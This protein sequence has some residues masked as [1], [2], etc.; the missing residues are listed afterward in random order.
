[1][2]LSLYKYFSST[3]E[4]K[5]RNGER[6]TTAPA[7][8][9]INNELFPHKWKSRH[10]QVSTMSKYKLNVFSTIVTTHVSFT[11]FFPFSKQRQNKSS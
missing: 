5:K 1:M 10:F 6:S 4:E 7:K 2:Q 11:T 8:K 9:Q 3:T